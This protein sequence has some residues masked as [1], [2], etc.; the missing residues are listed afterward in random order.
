MSY[1]GYTAMQQ[2]TDL[3][4]PVSAVEYMELINLAKKN[5]NETPQYTDQQINDYK[6]LGADNFNRYNTDWKGLV[7]KPMAL[8]QN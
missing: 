6:T 5:N 1:S 2:P 7:M 8:M 4:S 3:P